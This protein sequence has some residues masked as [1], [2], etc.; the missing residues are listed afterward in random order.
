MALM[1][2]MAAVDA[3]AMLLMDNVIA[4]G[5]LFKGG[6]C[7]GFADLG[8]SPPLFLSEDL[9]IGEQRQPLAGPQKAFGDMALGDINRPRLI[10]PLGKFLEATRQVSKR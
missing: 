5:Q 4:D 6:K 10:P 8:P 3:E 7:L 1:S 2:H 9:L